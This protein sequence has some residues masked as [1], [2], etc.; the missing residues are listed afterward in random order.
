MD[1]ITGHLCSLSWS[2]RE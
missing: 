2:W 1:N